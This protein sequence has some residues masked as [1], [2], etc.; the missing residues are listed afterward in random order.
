[1][2][3]LQQLKNSY[4]LALAQVMPR[5]NFRM[6]DNPEATHQKSVSAHLAIEQRVCFCVTRAQFTIVRFSRSLSG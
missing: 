5:R 6:A 1:M 2:Y 3:R 4:T